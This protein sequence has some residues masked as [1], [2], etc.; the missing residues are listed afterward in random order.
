MAAKEREF[1]RR[2]RDKWALAL[3]RDATSQEQLHSRWQLL[4]ILNKQLDIK[5]SN[6]S[7][8]IGQ[9]WRQMPLMI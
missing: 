1:S 9:T 2:A 8:V 7:H 6:S 4:M 5:L 3:S